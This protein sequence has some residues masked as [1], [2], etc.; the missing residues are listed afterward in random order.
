MLLRYKK[1]K[2][3]MDSILYIN[4]YPLIKYDFSMALLKN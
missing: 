1:S 4:I 3:Y 2:K